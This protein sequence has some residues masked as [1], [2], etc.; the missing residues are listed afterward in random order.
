MVR[1]ERERNAKVY[2]YITN[3]LEMDFLPI[4]PAATLPALLQWNQGSDTAG[5]PSPR[6]P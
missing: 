1:W 2:K 4:V 6:C 5:C 3:T